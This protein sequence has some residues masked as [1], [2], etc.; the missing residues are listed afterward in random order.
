MAQMGSTK[1]HQL[2]GNLGGPVGHLRWQLGRDGLQTDQEAMPPVGFTEPDRGCRGMQGD[3]GPREEDHPGGAGGNRK[4]HRRPEQRPRR[5]VK[6]LEVEV[7]EAG[8]GVR[9]ERLSASQT[10]TYDNRS[11]TG[12]NGHPLGHFG[13]SGSHDRHWLTGYPHHLPQ[14]SPGAASAFP[15]S[16]WAW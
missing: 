1:A 15:G 16:P 2:Q 3:A 8:A 12:Q 7:E 11:V 9:Q 14:P 13:D 6:R 10:R 5:P 4:Q